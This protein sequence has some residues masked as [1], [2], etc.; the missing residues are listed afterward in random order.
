MSVKYPDNSRL[1]RSYDGL[2]RLTSSEATGLGISS[3]D[4]FEDDLEVHYNHPNNT[5]NN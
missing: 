3:V 2:A 5:K 1:D 4:Y